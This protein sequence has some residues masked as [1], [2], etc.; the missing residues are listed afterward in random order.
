MP[1]AQKVADSRY[2]RSAEAWLRAS[3][4]AFIELCGKDAE[5]SAQRDQRVQAVA[6]LDDVKD[7]L[8]LAIA[9]RD[10]TRGE[11]SLSIAA[12]KAAIIDPERP[13]LK[14][15]QQLTAALVEPCAGVALAEPSGQP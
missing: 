11:V 5:C 13:E 10:A 9:A 12:S 8:P 3:K 1:A 14:A 2:D 6:T 7:R 4:T 15:S